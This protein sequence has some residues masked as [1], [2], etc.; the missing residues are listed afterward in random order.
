[1][2]RR[3]EEETEAAERTASQSTDESRAGS[4]TASFDSRS[5]KLVR[6]LSPRDGYR[7]T[8]RRSV[9][10]FARKAVTPR[11]SLVG[12]CRKIAGDGGERIGRRTE[13]LKLGMMRVS[14]REPFE[15]FLCKKPLAP[16]GPF[17]SRY[18]GCSDHSLIYQVI[19]G[20]DAFGQDGIS[21]SGRPNGNRTPNFLE[22]LKSR[23]ISREGCG[24]RPKA[25]PRLRRGRSVSGAWSD[26]ARRARIPTLIVQYIIA[27]SIAHFLRIHLTLFYYIFV[28]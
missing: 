19:Q 16:G 4:R 28:V 26:P 20:K 8:G 21:P 7:G 13:A 27:H 1:M 9:N 10:L 23:G 5:A 24:R 18:C 15:H 25:G 22:S 17:T 11:V 3:A 6:A 14:L 12:D 2:R